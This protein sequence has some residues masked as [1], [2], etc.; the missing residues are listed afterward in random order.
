MS[1]KLIRGFGTDHEIYLCLRCRQEVDSNEEIP[2]LHRCLDAAPYDE[3]CDMAAGDLAQPPFADAVTVDSTSR[4]ESRDS[5]SDGSPRQ[6]L[7]LTLAPQAPPSPANPDEHGAT[8][9]HPEAPGNAERTTD[10]ATF[11]SRQR[12]YSPL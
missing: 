1:L 12:E 11:R 6:I 7:S 4:C 3:S 9:R 10:S 8:R 2:A 5:N